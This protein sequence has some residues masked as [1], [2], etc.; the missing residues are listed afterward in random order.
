MRP[1]SD[2]G[3][4]NEFAIVSMQLVLGTLALVSL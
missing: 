1:V 4:R 3:P 2:D